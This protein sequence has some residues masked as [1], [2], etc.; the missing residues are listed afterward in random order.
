[1]GVYKGSCAWVVGGY[2]G[3][4]ITLIHSFIYSFAHFFIHSFLHSFISSLFITTFIL[5][6]IITSTH[7]FVN[8]TTTLVI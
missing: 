7:S 5:A 3:I 4:T 8:N 6:F 1:M 2:A